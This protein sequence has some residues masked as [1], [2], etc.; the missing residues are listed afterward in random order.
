MREAQWQEVAFTTT[1][2][3]LFVRHLQSGLPDKDARQKALAEVKGY[4]SAGSPFGVRSLSAGS[5]Q[6]EQANGQAAPSMKSTL[7]R[8]LDEHEE[9]VQLS[10]NQLWERLQSEGIRVGRTSVAEVLKERKQ[11][12]AA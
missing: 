7:R 6:A 3:A 8:Y 5:G 11:S 1:Y 10:V 2:R 9:A 4:L 12:V